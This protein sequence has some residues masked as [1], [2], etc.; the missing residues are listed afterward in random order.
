M[1]YLDREPRTGDWAELPSP[2]IYDNV[3]IGGII[4][5][6]IGGMGNFRFLR[7]LLSR[8]GLSVIDKEDLAISIGS[9]LDV[10]DGRIINEYNRRIMIDRGYVVLLKRLEEETNGM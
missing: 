1:I 4:V 6:V 8:G 10:L 7:S 2:S 9:T 3:D 5:E